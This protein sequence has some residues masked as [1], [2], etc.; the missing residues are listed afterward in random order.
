MS[1]YTTPANMIARHLY[2]SANSIEGLAK[3]VQE[4]VLRV[5]TEDGTPFL[6]PGSYHNLMSAIIELSRRIIEL[7]DDMEQ[8]G[9]EQR[10]GVGLASAGQPRNPAGSMP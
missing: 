6:N 9:K 10:V 3:L 4:D 2:E 5:D 7:S 8:L 1:D